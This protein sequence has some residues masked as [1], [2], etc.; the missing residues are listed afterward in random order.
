MNSNRVILTLALS[1]LFLVLSVFWDG[2]VLAGVGA[3]SSAP[4]V[5]YPREGDSNADGVMD[6]LSAE[7]LQMQSSAPEQ[8]VSILV[9]LWK[10]TAKGHLSVFKQL[11]GKVSHI[12]KRVS[13]GFAGSI[14]CKNVAKLAKKLG[15]DLC[16]IE[17]DQEGFPCL[18]HNNQMMRTDS[19]VWTTYG[20]TGS[21]NSSVAV[22][23]SGINTAHNDLG[24]PDTDNVYADP[25]DWRRA[26]SSWPSDTNYKVIG[27][28]D[29][30]KSSY[31]V[32]GATYANTV[33]SNPRDPASSGHGTH[34]A[35]IV[36]GAGEVNS[37]LK[38]VAP[39]TRLVGIKFCSYLS[40]GEKRYA[41]DFIAGLDWIL[42]AAY[43]FEWNV[44]PPWDLPS[45]SSDAAP[46]LGNLDPGLGN[47]TTDRLVGI[48]ASASIGEVRD[49][50]TMTTLRQPGSR[51]RASW[52]D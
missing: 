37:S 15:K 16:I 44:R 46:A 26:G 22:I 32:F 13:Y 10:P 34:M 2:S 11:G 8:Y 27:W 3:S 18:D 12:Y 52:T 17:Q 36:A 33:Y 51:R 45:M 30:T 9:T 5:T 14:P 49:I 1:I 25:D 24:D 19:V 35:G 48:N 23:D 21:V 20:Y 39:T 38:G 50:G 4:I 29:T 42:A 47:S 31:Y 6:G 43:I 40:L 28:K 7:V 41:S